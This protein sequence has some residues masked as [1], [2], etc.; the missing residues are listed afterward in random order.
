MS[1]IL[2]LLIIL[3]QF[4]FVFLFAFT[5]H[6]Y[7]GKNTYQF[8]LCALMVLLYGYEFVR[9]CRIL[10][11][12]MAFMNE[13]RLIILRIEHTILGLFLREVF[14]YAYRIYQ[15]KLAQR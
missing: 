2:Y 12:N 1:S 13:T 9:E 3:L 4:G 8:V 7:N 10:L 5:L 6:K 14:Y 15:K 11:G